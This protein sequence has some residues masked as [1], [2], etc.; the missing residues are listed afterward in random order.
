MVGWSSVE[1]VSELLVRCFEGKRAGVRMRGSND[2]WDHRAGFR[3]EV[4]ILPYLQ[5]HVRLKRL[6]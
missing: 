4:Q 3:V 6:F 2:G 5:L 1:G